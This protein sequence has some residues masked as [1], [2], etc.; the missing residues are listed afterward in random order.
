MLNDEWAAAPTNSPDQLIDFEKVLLFTPS[1]YVISRQFGSRVA[2]AL[3][4]RKAEPSG[5]S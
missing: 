3:G 2:R 5:G 1:F 4:T